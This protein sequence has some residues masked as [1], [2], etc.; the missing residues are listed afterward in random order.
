MPRVT[1]TW[2]VTDG[3][4]SARRL[5]ARE[6]I[7]SRSELRNEV[8]GEL[9]DTPNVFQVHWTHPPRRERR[10]RVACHWLGVIDTA[11]EAGRDF[12]IP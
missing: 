4:P 3:I 10:R 6:A 1:F 8:E 9:G 5:P 2:Q 11:I 7:A 12:F